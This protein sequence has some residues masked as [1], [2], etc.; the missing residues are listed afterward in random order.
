MKNYKWH[1]IDCSNEIS[2]FEYGFIVRNVAKERDLQ[3]L[4]R[5]GDRYFF[6]WFDVD[7]Y[8]EDIESGSTWIDIQGICSST[9][10]SKAEFLQENSVSFLCDLIS[11]YGLHE[12]FANYYDDGFSESEIR[13]RLK[14]A[15]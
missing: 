4:Y 14:K 6:S 9:G 11:Y 7:S 2:L 12:F 5:N 8:K 15:L 10:L 13:Q 3:V 1:G